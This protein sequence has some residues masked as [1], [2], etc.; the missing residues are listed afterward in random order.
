MSLELSDYKFKTYYWPPPDDRKG[1]E[2]YLIGFDDDNQPY[3][4]KWEKHKGDEGWMATTL[5]D[6]KASHSTAIPKNYNDADVDKLIKVWADA[7]A[8]ARS[9]FRVRLE[10]KKKRERND[11]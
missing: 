1:R 2:N 11:D 8:L 5:S 4:V 7:P 10:N 3:I 6:S 9:V